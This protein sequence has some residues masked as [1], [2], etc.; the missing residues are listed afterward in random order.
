MV[1]PRLQ[2]GA[3]PQKIRFDTR[4][5]A[6]ADGSTVTVIRARC[7]ICTNTGEVVERSASA[8]LA[9]FTEKAV[10]AARTK[11]HRR[12]L[13]ALAAK[14]GETKQA[15][16]TPD[17]RV[18]DIA[19]IMFAEKRS[20][21]D[22]GQM[23]PG[24]V[25]TYQG[26]WDRHVEPKL[27]G[28]AVRWVGVSRCDQFL[29]DLRKSH[30]YATVKG[31]RSV[32]S[33]IL[34][35]AV[36]RE[37]IP[38]PNPIQGCADIPGE[39]RRPVKSLEAGEAVHIWRRLSDLALTPGPG[40]NNRRYRP[41]LC[42][43][44]VP[45][46]WLWMLGTGD[47]ISNALAVRWRF[48]D[49]DTGTARLGPN[50]IR[51]PGEGLIISEGTSKS[52]EVEGVDL[53]EQVIAMLL[54][55]QQ[56]QGHSPMGLVFVDTFGGLLDPSNVSSKKLRPALKA[57]GYG[58]VSSHWCRRT[59]GSELN[60]AGMTLMEIAG[61]LRHADSR[62]TERHYV[63]KRGGNPKV[64]AAIEAM[65]ATAPARTVLPLDQHAT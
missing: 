4:T 9:D 38:A 21:V 54:A 62:T 25:R 34:A 63:A 57:I 23:S 35:V 39:G 18:R 8:P 29:K 6:V 5:R 24:S 48:I 33:E 16:I 45:D 40:V 30:G 65:L 22:A 37:A 17:T 52:Q 19:K 53:P 10:K 46:L 56:Q 11:A 50:V 49:M 43:P 26:H 58:H 36:R 28:L 31:A 7:Y 41:T 32:L 59:L 64:K 47:R 61:R 2:P 44:L 27:G 12:L 20:L 14:T 55:R 13:A 1:N 3:P 42:D 15:D 51:V 60:A